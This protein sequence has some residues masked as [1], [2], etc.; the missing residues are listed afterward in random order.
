LPT[1]ACYNACSG[2]GQ[3]H[4]GWRNLRFF[5][6]LAIFQE[7]RSGLLR[8]PVMDGEFTCDRF[9]HDQGCAGCNFLI[10]G[11]T[12]SAALGSEEAVKP[13]ES[14]GVIMRFPAGGPLRQQGRQQV[15]NPRQHE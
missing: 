4:Q 14:S 7:A 5:G 13:S 15:Q 6:A 8:M 11:K 12:Q 9:R 2:Q 3:E 10:V 1:T